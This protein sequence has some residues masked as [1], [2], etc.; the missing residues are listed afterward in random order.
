MSSLPSPTGRALRTA[1][2]LVLFA[3]RPTAAGAREWVQTSSGRWVYET[4]FSTSGAFRCGPARRLVGGTCMAAGNTLTLTDRDGDALVLEF[5]GASATFTLAPGPVDL[6]VGTILTRRIGDGTF[7]SPFS[8]DWHLFTLELD[9]LGQRQRFSGFVRSPTGTI[10]LDPHGAAVMPV[11]RPPAHLRYTHVVY[12][13]EDSPMPRLDMH[14]GATTLD[15]RIGLVP[16]PSTWALLG[17]GLIAVGASA[18][19]RRRGA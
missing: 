6:A 10:W 4:G 12:T 11:E 13:F 9:G 19:R 2:V 5:L 14:G 15:A 3:A 7:E 1:V 18:R 16:E 17:T 8:R